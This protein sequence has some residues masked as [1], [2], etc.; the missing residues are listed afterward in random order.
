LGVGGPGLGIG[1]WG[2]GIGVQAQLTD[3]GRVRIYG[4]RSRLGL[5]GENS[6]RKRMA[7]A[8]AGTVKI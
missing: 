3:H 5:V 4:E 2:L 1:G 7:D 6:L 8:I